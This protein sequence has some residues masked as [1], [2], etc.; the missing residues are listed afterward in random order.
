[1]GKIQGIGFQHTRAHIARSILESVAYAGRF[2]IDAMFGVG[3]T[4]NELRFDGGGARSALW[5]QIICDVVNKP[6]IYTQ[7]DEGTALG[8][9]ILASL[10]LKLFPSVEKAV[11]AMVH[12]RETM[13]PNPENAEAYNQGYSMFQQTLMSNIQEIM[14]HV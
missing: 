12:S 6:G 2:S 7:V 14:K 1:M 11:N 13:S 8:A 5:R 3:V 10:G 4:L 9:A